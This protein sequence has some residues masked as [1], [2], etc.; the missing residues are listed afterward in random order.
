MYLC[1][2]IKCTSLSK[3]W[4]GALVLELKHKKSPSPLNFYRLT[5]TAKLGKSFLISACN[6]KK[7]KKKAR[8]ETKGFIYLAVAVKL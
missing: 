7:K 4:H 1:L 3:Q 5:C 2:G 8:R 6:I